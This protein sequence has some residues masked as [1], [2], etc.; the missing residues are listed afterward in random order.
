[1]RI[2][3]SIL[4]PVCIRSTTHGFS[5]VEVLVALVVI[6]VGMLGMAGLYVN[7]LRSNGTAISRTEAVNLAADLAERI[8]A[9]PLGQANYQPATAPAAANGCY[10]GTPCAP[11]QLA[12]DDLLLWNQDVMNALPGNATTAV[13]YT[14]GVCTLSEAGGGVPDAYSITINWSQALD[15]GLANLSYTLPVQ[16]TIPC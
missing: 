12:S 16:V 10:T 2:R 11:A 4:R 1:M 14:A 7:T 8:R 13:S 9:N 6:G 5:L 15:D 3:S